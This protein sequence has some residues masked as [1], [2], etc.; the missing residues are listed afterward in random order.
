MK[1]KICVYTCITGNY[2]NLHEIE[3]VEKEV[4]YLCFTNNKNIKSSTWKII[5]IEDNRL[6]NQRLSRKIKMLGHPIISDNYEISVWMDAS[7]IFKKS[8]INFVNKYLKDSPFAAIK[9]HCRNCIYDEALEC[10]KQRKDDRKTILN[11]IDFLKKSGYPSNNGLYEMTVFIKKHNDPVVIKTMELWFETICNYSKRDQLSFMYCVWKTG[12]KIDKI[13]INV[14]ENEYFV[15][16]RHNSIN[17]IDVC[18]I[19]FVKD[20]YDYN[21]D[22]DYDYEIRE[23]LYIINTK[24]PCNTN[25][26]KIFPLKTP[27]VIYKNLKI[28]TKS[29]IDINVINSVDYKDKQVFYNEIPIIEVKG[30]FKKGDKFKFEVELEKMNEDYIYELVDYLGY[31]NKKLEIDNSN[32]SNNNKKLK[33]I[34]DNY[35]QQISSITNSRGWIFLEKIRKIA[36]RNK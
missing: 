14:W 10:I 22:L 25:C 19:L 21:Y 26:I 12:M 24:I 4:D 13:N 11:H 9:H 30:F 35:Q 3:N 27:C 5:Y 18:R 8:I 32:L 20:Y 33:Q 16:I 6:D 17:K 36:R 15:W 31:N 28:V 7:V 34:N 29:K 1:K 23:N 2:D